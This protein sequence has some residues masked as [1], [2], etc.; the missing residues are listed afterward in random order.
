MNILFKYLARMFH[1]YVNKLIENLPDETKTMRKLDLVLTGCY[2][3]NISFLIG[4]LLFLKEMEKLGYIKVCRISGNGL[5]TLAGLLYFSD[6][7][8][9]LSDYDLKTLPE[10]GRLLKDKVPKHILKNK[11]FI[12]YYDV[13]LCVKITKS[14]Y[15]TPAKLIDEVIK[16]C[17][18]PFVVDGNIAYKNQFMDG[19]SPYVFDVKR[20]RQI[21][22]CSPLNYRYLRVIGSETSKVLTSILDIHGF[23]VVKQSSSICSY[24]NEW[25]CYDRNIELLKYIVERIVVYIIYLVLVVKPYVPNV[26]MEKFKTYMRN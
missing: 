1:P 7:I 8:N 20:D 9:I 15:K 22:Y 25:T 14:K 18:L 12:S 2:R 16:S 26:V 21:L 13:N 4:S 23:F 5:G 11:L 10:V 3:F 24:L 17:Y 6:S 19:L